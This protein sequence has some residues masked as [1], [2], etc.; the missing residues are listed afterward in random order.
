MREWSVDSEK[1]ILIL[2]LMKTDSR[3]KLLVKMFFSCKSKQKINLPILFSLSLSNLEKTC[4]SSSNIPSHAITE[5]SL[6]MDL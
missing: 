2:K 5:K 6:N 4:F 3:D 1:Q